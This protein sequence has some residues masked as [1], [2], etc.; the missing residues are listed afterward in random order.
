MKQQIKI[1]VTDEFYADVIT[2]RNKI[3]KKHKLGGEVQIN[4]GKDPTSFDSDETLPPNIPP[5][6]SNATEQ[7]K[8]NYNDDNVTKFGDIFDIKTLMR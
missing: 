6:G 8:I 3:I 5:T 7:N 4:E 1:H 2:L